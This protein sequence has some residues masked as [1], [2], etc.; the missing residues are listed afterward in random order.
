MA[1]RPRYGYGPRLG[2]NAR[3]GLIAYGAVRIPAREVSSASETVLDRNTSRL[4][5]NGR[6]LVRR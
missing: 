6:V 5:R 2:R 3:G 4:G 1:G